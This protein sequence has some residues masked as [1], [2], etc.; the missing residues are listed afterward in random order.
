MQMVWNTQQSQEMN[1]IPNEKQI[2]SILFQDANLKVL[3]GIYEGLAT[4]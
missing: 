1:S 3:I 2:K 4:Q